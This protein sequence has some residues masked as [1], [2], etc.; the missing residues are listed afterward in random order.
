MPSRAARAVYGEVAGAFEACAD[1]LALAGQ[2]GDDGDEL[3][4][5]WTA[6]RTTRSPRLA[7]CLRARGIALDGEGSA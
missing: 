4:R 2:D 6:W 7:A 3:L 1:V 5:L